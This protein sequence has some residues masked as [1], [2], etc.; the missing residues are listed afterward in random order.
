VADLGDAQD[1]GGGHAGL[2]WSIGHGLQIGVDLDA[3]ALPR[4]LCYGASGDCRCK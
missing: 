3:A 1:L 2:A 4:L